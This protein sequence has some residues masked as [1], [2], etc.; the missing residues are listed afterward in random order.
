M[1]AYSI[2]L[3][4]PAPPRFADLPQRMGYTV[5]KPFSFATGASGTTLSAAV[6]SDTV[7][8]ITIP[9]NTLVLRGGWEIT[10]ADTAANSGALALSTVAPSTVLLASAAVTAVG[11]FF[12]TTQSLVTSSATTTAR[13][14]VSTGTV[15]A[16]G[17]VILFNVDLNNVVTT[18]N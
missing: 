18:V 2:I 15:N 17:R 12:G 14:T 13:L 16:A 6:T 9:A 8:L 4:T 3:T 10:T 11:L 5:D 7:D 1:T